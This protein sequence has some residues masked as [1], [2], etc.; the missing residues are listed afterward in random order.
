[1]RSKR[2]EAI[3]KLK[4]YKKNVGEDEYKIA[5]KELGTIFEKLS[6]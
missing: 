4:Q 3:E 1:M 6:E 5:E 2:S